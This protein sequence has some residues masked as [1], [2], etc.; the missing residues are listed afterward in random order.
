MAIPGAVVRPMAY[1]GGG[2][3][4]GLQTV[5]RRPECGGSPH[6][7]LCLPHLQLL[8]ISKYSYFPRIDQGGARRGCGFLSNVA[9]PE[10]RIERNENFIPRDLPRSSAK[11]YMV[12]RKSPVAEHLGNGSF[13]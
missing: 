6:Y 4:P 11:D 9:A 3:E 13:Y 1:R 5:W 12:W 2:T 10:F 8:L 7:I